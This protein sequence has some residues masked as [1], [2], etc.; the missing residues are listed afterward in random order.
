MLRIARIVVATFAFALVSGISTNLG[1]S[2][3]MSTYKLAPGDR[4]L[5]HV[6]GQAELSGDFLIDG[7]GN[8][9]MPLVG[10]VPISG[11]TIEESRR[12]LIER[13]A[14]GFLKKPE[15]SVRITELRPIYV[16]GSVRAPGSYPFRFGLSAL[17]AVVMAGGFGS[18]ENA[19]KADLLAAE[20][21]VK[22]LEGARQNLMF[23][24]DYIDAERTGRNILM[25][26]RSPMGPQ[27]PTSCACCA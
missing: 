19:A 10:A 9:Q 23:R 1:A 22:V 18:E 20:E 25:F 5:I 21:R 17:N 14:D 8:I 11:T 2:G 12:R 6:F 16:L 13:L 4:I 27:A 15:V 3:D 7:V 24:L 26:P